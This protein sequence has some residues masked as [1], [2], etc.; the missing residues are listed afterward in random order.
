M[1]RWRVP[2]RRLKMSA[3]V[4]CRP[5]SWRGC[6]GANPVIPPSHRLCTHHVGVQHV[7]LAGLVEADDKLVAVDL[8]DDPVAEL[9]VEHPLAGPVTGPTARRGGDELAFD[10]LGP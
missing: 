10:G 1:P 4:C 9:V 2:G 6:E 8:G 7:L 5:A 3:T